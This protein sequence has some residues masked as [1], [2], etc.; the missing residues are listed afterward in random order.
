[1][2]YSLRVLSWLLVAGLAWSAGWLFNIKF[3]DEYK[4]VTAIYNKKIAIAAKVTAPTRVLLVGGSGTHFGIS[5]QQIEQQLGVPVIN[6]GL[7]AGLGLDA[8]L[9]AAT[10]QIRRG[11]VIL[12]APE[13]AFLSTTNG[14]GRGRLAA[15][16][17]V[18]IGDPGVGETDPKE[19]V[20]KF[21]LLGSFGSPE[22]ANSLRKLTFSSSEQS[23]RYS[24]DLSAR[25]DV[26]QPPEGSPKKPGMLRQAVSDYSIERIIGFQK[27]V[28]TAG[29]KLVIELPWFYAR[30]NQKGLQNALK[31]ATQLQQ[32]APVLYNK[33]DLNLKSDVSLFSDTP[34]H[35]S[36]KGRQMRS[37]ALAQQLKP[38]IK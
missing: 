13:Y 28:E 25:G 34:Y 1:M 23:H 19:I 26:L 6:L 33:T 5:A 8:I 16:F 11:D 12:F 30:S 24:Q 21:L 35:L 29:A 10:T 14:N 36:A 38:F 20:N 9:G 15:Q 3:S 18:E 22:I 4:W 17:G 2:N 37:M 7:H 32:I 27:Q 31:A